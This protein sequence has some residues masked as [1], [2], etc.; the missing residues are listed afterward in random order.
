MRLAK[1]L[2]YEF[3]T[4]IHIHIYLK[5][6]FKIKSYTYTDISDCRMAVD[7]S[8]SYR[9]SRR[10]YENYFSLLR[11][12]DYDQINKG[13]QLLLRDSITETKYSENYFI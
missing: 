7:R 6:L 5:S 3:F 1:E 2:Y 10:P 11:F 9:D 8:S 4:F 13:L 12:S